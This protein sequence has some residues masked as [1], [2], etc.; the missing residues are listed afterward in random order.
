M[1]SLLDFVNTYFWQPILRDDF[2]NPVDTA[3]YALILVAA[4]WLLYEKFFVKF[5]V[6][7]DRRFM[8][9]L[10]GWIVIGSAL[11][12]V[13]DVAIL[14]VFWL[15]T[16]FIY[17]LVFAAAF[18]L[19]LFARWLDRKEKIPYWKVWGYPAWAAAFLTIAALPLRNFYG[20]SLA[21]GLMAAWFVLFYV[22]RSALPK[23]FSWWNVAALQAHMVDAS[24]SFVAV[25]YFS[26]FEKH[27][28][29]G[30]F[31]AAYGPWT[32]FPL[33]LAVLLPALWAIDKY[34]KDELEKRYIKMIIII[35]G[36]A[37]GLRNLLAVTSF[38]PS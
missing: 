13:E 30:S 22:L 25:T 36:F 11:R 31:A 20:A 19:L 16:P 12:V 9:A 18:P 10:G 23:F 29:A 27:V 35:L 37:L 2:Y 28:L 32:L 14:D 15:R 38:A 6:R 26:F 24:A 7:I 1:V 34:G 21:I 17:L 3:T 4:V 8:F 5:K 33:K